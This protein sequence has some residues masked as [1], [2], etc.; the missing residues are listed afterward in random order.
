MSPQTQNV[1]DETNLLKATFIVNTDLND[2]SWSAEANL[3]RYYCGEKL[4]MK[5]QMAASVK[6]SVDTGTQKSFSSQNVT[7][8]GLVEPD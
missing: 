5:A 2:Y 7:F 1:P 6:S 8:K 4:V 3:E